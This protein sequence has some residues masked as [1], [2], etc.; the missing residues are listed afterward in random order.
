MSPV[1]SE[2]VDYGARMATAD[3][4]IPDQSD[5]VDYGIRVAV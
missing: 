4:A 2:I 3:S 1:E 5:A